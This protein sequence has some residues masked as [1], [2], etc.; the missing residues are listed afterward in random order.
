[1]LTLSK[2]TNIPSN[3][4]TMQILNANLD[5]RPIYVDLE[6][7]HMNILAI[8][9][10]L[11]EKNKIFK[12]IS[13]MD[14]SRPAFVRWVQANNL[15]RFFS[16]T[17]TG[18]VSTNKDS[19]QTAL[20]SGMEE[21][22]KDVVRLCA[23]MGKLTTSKQS[24]IP[25]LQ[26]PQSKL[27]SCDGH[28]ML[29]VVPQWSR[30]NTGRLGMSKPAIQNIPRELQDI[31]TVPRGYK[32]I[33][34]DSGQVE[35]RITYSAYVKDPQIKALIELYNDAYFGLLHYCTMPQSFIDS[36]TTTFEKMEITD[37]M[38]AG[39]KKI[40]TY[41]N[42][43]M[44]GSTKEEDAIKSAMIKRIGNHPSRLQLIESIKD[45]LSRGIT[46]F[47][48]YFGTPIDIGNSQKLQTYDREKEL[49]K[50]AIN[51][52]IQATAADLM[53]YSVLQANSI[54][55]NETKNSTIICYIHDA[56]LFCVE[57]DRF[58]V[59]KDRLCD[60]V[61]YQ[62]DDWIKIYAEPEIYQFN[63]NGFYTHYPY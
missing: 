21:H 58:D 20:T 60:I 53:R 49:V 5:E 25:F 41:G 62:V 48:T 46:V 51:N 39:R 11:S 6:K 28:R 63:E 15:D 10:Q 57:E 50:L 1:M 9:R 31:I 13:G 52:P 37:S 34:T 19:I 56:G 12:E 16:M 8:E 3:E 61:S 14:Y 44:Y 36:R 45:T 54:L 4:M 18:D 24:I 23:S 29:E 38:K 7:I 47:P 32:L 26:N 35:P 59:V 40:K 2:T 22:H 17:P 30:Q 42:A 33:H 27:P 43:V 55:L